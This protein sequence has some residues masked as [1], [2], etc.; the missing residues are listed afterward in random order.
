MEFIKEELDT[1]VY[2]IKERHKVHKKRLKGLEPPWSED[3]VMN[4]VFFTNPYRE[5]DKATIW[6]R[7]N[8]RD[9]LRDVDSVIFATI[10]FRRINSILVDKILLRKCPLY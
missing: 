8:V 2:W 9:P 10:L 4:G 6:F 3:A 5:N 1:F 7:E